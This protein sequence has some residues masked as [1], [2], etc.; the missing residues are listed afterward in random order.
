MNTRTVSLCTIAAGVFWL[1]CFSLVSVEL[2][3]CL[4]GPP[5]HGRRWTS[6]VGNFGLAFGMIAA[7]LNVRHFFI[8]FAERERSAFDLGREVGNAQVKG[9]RGLP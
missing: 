6:P 7:T 5:T 4:I 3:A 1:L 9:V 2:V 8:R